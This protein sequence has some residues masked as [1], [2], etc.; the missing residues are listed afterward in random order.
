MTIQCNQEIDVP[1]TTEEDGRIV[2]KLRDEVSKCTLRHEIIHAF[3]RCIKFTK[4]SEVIPPGPDPE[5]VD[6]RP[7]GRQL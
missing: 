5:D 6:L 2:I 7:T 4:K 3:N 1:Y